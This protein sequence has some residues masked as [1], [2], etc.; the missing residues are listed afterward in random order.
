MGGLAWKRPNRN[1]LVPLGRRPPCHRLGDCMGGGGARTLIG[2]LSPRFL[3]RPM[4]V[5]KSCTP[6]PP[7]CN[8]PPLVIPPTRRPSLACFSSCPWAVRPA[9]RRPAAGEGLRGRQRRS[10][11]KLTPMIMFRDYAYVSV[12]NGG[13]SGR[14]EGTFVDGRSVP[15]TLY[16][17]LFF[18]WPESRDLFKKSQKNEISRNPISIAFL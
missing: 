14:T 13:S 16:R 10:A 1:P 4:D 17:G 6:P 7:L 5:K 11:V 3:H 12:G 15:T 2:F 18:Y 9:E 8:H